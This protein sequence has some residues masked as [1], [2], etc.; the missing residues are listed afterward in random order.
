MYLGC[1]ESSP[2]AVRS[3]ATTPYHGVLGDG[4]VLPD[5]VQDLGLG[6]D[7]ATPLD[8]QFEQR[9]RL[10]FERYG[11][12]RPCE[13]PGRKIQ[14]E[15]VEPPGYSVPHDA[16]HPGRMLPQPGGAPPLRPATTST[17]RL[18]SPSACRI[19]VFREDAVKL[20]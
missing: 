14:L 15:C 20:R 17:G 5:L 9:Q 4:G 2:R 8:Q 12:A 1:F 13:P 18:L 10:G 3:W 11:L 16:F 19:R 7:L 6:D